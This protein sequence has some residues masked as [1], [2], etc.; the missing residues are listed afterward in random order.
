M[1]M[2]RPLLG[3]MVRP[4]LVGIGSRQPEGRSEVGVDKPVRGFVNVRDGPLERCSSL[5]GGLPVGG[6]LA[7][8]LLLLLLLLLSMLLVLLVRLVLPAAGL[9]GA[10]V[11][12]RCGAR[13]NAR[14]RKTTRTAGRGGCC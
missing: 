9:A 13:H 2:A 7:L 3:V 12:R 11:G 6:V 14:R 5:T 4:V 1:T 8:R 10:A